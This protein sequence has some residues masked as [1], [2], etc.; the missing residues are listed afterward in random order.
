[1][2]LIGGAE[3]FQINLWGSGRGKARGRM[4]TGT[5]GVPTWVR[6]AGTSVRGDIS[7][8]RYMC[9]PSHRSCL[10]TDSG[11]KSSLDE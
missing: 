11:G 10:S 3:K 7:V 9:N 1:M 4:S 6:G 5:A 8:Y 2:L